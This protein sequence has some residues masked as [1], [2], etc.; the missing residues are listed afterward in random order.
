MMQTTASMMSS[1]AKR[2]PNMSA[3]RAHGYAKVCVS[4]IRERALNESA[5]DAND[6]TASMI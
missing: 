3:E 6:T 4:M 2:E 5:D 1:S